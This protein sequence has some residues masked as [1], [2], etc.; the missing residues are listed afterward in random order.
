MAKLTPKGFV[1]IC[2][3][4][5]CTESLDLSK[6]ELKDAG[7]IMSRWLIEGCTIF[8]FFTGN[9]PKKPGKCRCDDQ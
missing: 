1:C 8:P 6:M 5:V 4:G 3:C 9:W 2:Q 7:K